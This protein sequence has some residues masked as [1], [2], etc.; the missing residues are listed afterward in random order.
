M[1][2]RYS[3]M[4]A[5]IL[6]TGAFVFCAAVLT[7]AGARAYL[8]VRDDGSRIHT[9]RVSCS[10]LTGQVRSC[11]G[12]VFIETDAAKGTVLCLSEHLGDEEYLTRI[13]LKDG[14]LT[15]SLQPESADFQPD[16]G[17]PLTALSAFYAEESGGLIRF[18][19]T[20]PDEQGGGT[21]RFSV[22]TRRTAR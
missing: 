21:E 9:L 19:V 16:Q 6:L 11:S 13:Y 18:E 2:R 7:A 14:M 4:L 3:G 12:D 8:S 20:L 15:E 5:P 1:S 17:E 10:Y 22:R